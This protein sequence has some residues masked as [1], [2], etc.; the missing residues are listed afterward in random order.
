MKINKLFHVLVVAGAS[1]TVG[2]AACGSDT[3]N[4]TPAA[5]GTGSAG[6]GASAGTAGSAD[7][8]AA[9]CNNTACNL[10]TV[11][12]GCCCWLPAGSAMG[13]CAQEICPATETC[14][15]GRGR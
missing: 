9:Q 11:C 12:N 8:C 7:M 4:P 15:V 3:T 5:G 10:G 2:L 6:T 14:C 1:S 13:L